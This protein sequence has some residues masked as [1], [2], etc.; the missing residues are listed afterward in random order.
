MKRLELTI[1]GQKTTALAGTKIL[2]ILDIEDFSYS[3]NPI[4]AAKANGMLVSLQESIEGNTTIETVRL[5]SPLGKRVYRKTLCF[6][7]CY[8]SALIAPE[9]TLI[10][11]HSLGDGYYFRYRNGEKPDTKRLEEVM[12][13]AISDSLPIEIAELTHGEALEYAISHGLNE[14]AELLKTINA[15]SYR[16]AKL[17][18]CYEMYYEPMLP[19]VKP[20]GLWELKEY[21]DGLLLRYPQSRSPY[22]LM[23]FSDNPLLFSVFKENKAYARILGISSV[24][25]LNSKARSGEISKTILL[26]EALHRRRIS[27]ISRAIKAKGTV[28]AVFIA[29]PSSSGKTTFSLRLSDELRVDGFDPVKISLDDY[30]LPSSEVPVDEDGEKDYE[31]LEALNLPL[32]R[33][34]LTALIAGESVHLAEFSFKDRTTI[35]RKESVK[36]A[37]NSILVIEGIHGLNPQLI[38]EMKAENAFRIYISALTV[39]NLDTRSRISTTD[40]RILRRMVRDYRTRGFDA[41]DTLSRWPSVERGEKNHIFPFQNNAD[42]MINS[43]LEYEL[44]VLKTYA[45]PLLRSVG[46][47]HG[48]SYATARRLLDEL[49]FFNPIP[50]EFVPGDSLLR[51][52]IGGSVYGAI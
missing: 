34:Q 49:E 5:I 40:N 23:P 36:L 15:S 20:L 11:G 29:G 16:F 1:D 43:S 24:G 45:V 26:S 7:L 47:E 21:Q 10:I 35:F 22:T 42:V 18:S 12:N 41:L 17:G 30:Y 33:K 19:T 39:V 38:P 37:E 2:D 27:D 50:P 28:K 31:V 4:V 25:E 51:E 13:K 9:R 6:L 14:T 32:L 44:G 46:K 3:S 48:D 52:F 8:A